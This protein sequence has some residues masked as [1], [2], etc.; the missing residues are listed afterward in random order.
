MFDITIYDNIDKLYP[1]L[2]TKIFN[3][4]LTYGSLTTKNAIFQPSFYTFF[5][6]KIVLFQNE[7]IRYW[8]I[9]KEQG[10]NKSSL[11]GMIY[12]HLV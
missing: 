12:D 7:W 4:N 5:K 6:V 10:C 3:I 11:R 8:I 9:G 1:S 2:H